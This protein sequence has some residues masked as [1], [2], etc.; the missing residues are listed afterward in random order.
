MPERSV[1][2]RR[3]YRTSPNPALLALRPNR[4]IKHAIIG[5]EHEGAVAS[6]AIY[7]PGAA[8][9]ILLCP[10]I[11]LLWRRGP[12]QRIV[13]VRVCAPELAKPA[14]WLVKTGWRGHTGADLLAIAPRILVDRKSTRL[15]SSH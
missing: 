10:A 8:A 15:N 13:D 1:H 9:E 3:I 7:R 4:H 12:A 11:A 14:N 6:G 2:T 5:E